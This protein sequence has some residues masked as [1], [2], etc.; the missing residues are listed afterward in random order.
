M[1]VAQPSAASLL[2]LFADRS[3]EPDTLLSAGF[4]V[5]CTSSNVKRKD[6]AAQL[7][8][9][10]F[11][12]LQDQGKVTLDLGGRTL[13]GIGRRQV[14]ASLVPGTVVRK[15]PARPSPLAAAA[16]SVQQ[17][18]P[19]PDL[20]QYQHLP[21]M[22]G[23]AEKMQE[24]AEQLAKLGISMPG[25]VPSEPVT[26]Q[27]PADTGPPFIL[28]DAILW[29][30]QEAGGSAPV[31]DVI[32]SWFGRDEHEPWDSV[33]ARVARELLEFGFGDPRTPAPGGSPFGASSAPVSPDCERRAE[34]E[35]AATELLDRW[36]AFLGTEDG[37]GETLLERCGAAI[38]SR[39]YDE[40][41]H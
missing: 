41:A 20:S 21:G 17:M 13:A 7:F 4:A 31:R 24:A 35:G 23:M 27:P 5:P 22:E 39:R 18:G 37:L 36:I 10:S 28:E 30:L 11:W 6:L 15:P 40:R 19:L 2:Y 38:S 34:L 33:I 1:S 25:Q 8:A 14:T 9:I 12:S 3:V 26:P 29:Q 32:R 16:A